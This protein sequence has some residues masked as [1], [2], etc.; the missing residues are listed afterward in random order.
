MGLA[1]VVLV[2]TGTLFSPQKLA[3]SLF[4]SFMS[5]VWNKRRF[6]RKEFSARLRTISKKKSLWPGNPQT[7]VLE[8]ACESFSGSWESFLFQ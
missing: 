3:K 7:V 5:R 4:D 1:V 6:G 2:N 8:I